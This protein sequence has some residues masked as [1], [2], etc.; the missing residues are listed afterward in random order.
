MTSNDFKVGDHV[1]DKSYS[2]NSVMAI[3]TAIVPTYTLAYLDDRVSITRFGDHLRPLTPEE[4]AEAVERAKKKMLAAI[5]AYQN[6][7]K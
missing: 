3:V 2:S 1:V 5:E 6:T 4:K 7:L